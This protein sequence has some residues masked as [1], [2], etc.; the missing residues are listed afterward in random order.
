V[1]SMASAGDNRRPAPAV[2]FPDQQPFLLE[3]GDRETDRTPGASKSFTRSSS[4]KRSLG[5]KRR[6]TIASVSGRSDR[7]NP[8]WQRMV[9]IFAGITIGL[10]NVRSVWLTGRW[11]SRSLRGFLLVRSNPNSPVRNGDLFR[12]TEYQFSGELSHV[13][14]FF[15]HCGACREMLR[16]IL[17]SA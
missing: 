7:S 17:A 10:S 5:R 14:Q 12:L 9:L 1:I 8:T 6:V 16:P 4:I 3:P 15:R 11:P 13:A 2:R